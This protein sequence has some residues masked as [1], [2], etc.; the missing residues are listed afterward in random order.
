MIQIVRFAVL[1]ECTIGRLYLDREPLY[2][3]IERPWVNNTPFVSCI[4]TGRYP[5]TRVDSPSYGEDTWM[6]DE[7]PNRTH[8][9][10]HV[11]NVADNVQGCIGM[12]MDLYTD[13]S[14]VRQSRIAV[15]DFYQRTKDRSSEEIEISNGFI[16]K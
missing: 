11:A 16:Y 12:G 2:Y 3:T 8:I 13:L 7:V 4:P 14:G 1:A 9:L 15:D 10:F 6:V 5:V